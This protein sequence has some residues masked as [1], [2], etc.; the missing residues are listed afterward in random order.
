MS[1]EAAGAPDWIRDVGDEDFEREVLERSNEVPVVVDFW[2]PWCGPCV[3]FARVVEAFAAEAAGRAIVAK[4]N[5]D[6]APGLAD[7][8]EIRGVPTVAVFRGGRRVAT[9]VGAA[10]PAELARLVAE[11]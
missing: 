9:R 2:A 10:P 5:I 7:R 11:A 8:Y 4:V 1:A 3:A 6:E